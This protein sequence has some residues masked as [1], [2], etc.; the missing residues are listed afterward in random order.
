MNPGLIQ[1]T[2]L[3]A[4]FFLGAAVSHAAAMHQLLSFEGKVEIGK[5]NTT[6]WEPASTNATLNAGD[7]VRTGA[8]SRAQVRLSTRAVLPISENTVITLGD[9]EGGA[10]SAAFNLEVGR[11][12]F[13]GNDKPGKTRLRTRSVAGA[14]R[15]TEFHIEVAEDCSMARLIWKMNTANSPSSPGRALLLKS[16]RPQSCG[17]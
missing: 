2:V 12:L 16:E 4:A 6:T 14:V 13:L 3:V 5:S 7:R 15:G 11:A 17:R 10:D 8:D 1:R 9:S